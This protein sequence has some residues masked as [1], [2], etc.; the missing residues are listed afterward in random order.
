MSWKT[1][2]LT[3]VGRTHHPRSKA[4]HYTLSQL[5]HTGLISVKSGLFAELWTN[6]PPPSP[7]KAHYLFQVPRTTVHSQVNIYQSTGPLDRV[8]ESLESPPPPPRHHRRITV[9]QQ[10]GPPQWLTTRRKNPPPS[11]A[12]GRC[13]PR[14]RRRLLTSP[15]PR[16]ASLCS[17]FCLRRFVG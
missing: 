16:Q 4:L 14:Q 2:A 10:N 15:P 17:L 6:W 7:S 1:V 5:P 12:R 11:Q 13:K 9:S 3:S 8:L